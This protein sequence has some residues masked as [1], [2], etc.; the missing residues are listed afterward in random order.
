[1]CNAG[2]SVERVVR[3]LVGGLWD[4]DT[5]LQDAY[6]RSFLSFIVFTS[7]FVCQTK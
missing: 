1:M 4:K 3:E 6:L 2:S 7:N 5:Y